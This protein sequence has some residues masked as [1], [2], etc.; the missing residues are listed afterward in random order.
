LTGGATLKLILILIL[1]P[2]VGA[3]RQTKAMM[4]K[5]GTDPLDFETVKKVYITDEKSANT[6]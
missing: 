2:A 1:I 6:R 3:T 4:Q 5:Q